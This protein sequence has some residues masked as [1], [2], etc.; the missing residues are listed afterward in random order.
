MITLP[1]EGTFKKVTSSIILFVEAIISFLSVNGPYFFPIASPPRHNNVKKLAVSAA[2]RTTHCSASLYH[3][4]LRG[5]KSSPIILCNWFLTRPLSKV[6]PL[7]YLHVDIWAH[8]QTGRS[9][10]VH[11]RE[12]PGYCGAEPQMRPKYS[13]FAPCLGLR[14]NWNY[15]RTGFDEVDGDE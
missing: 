10:F 12:A 15:K 1:S 11:W 13:L 9:R 8:S 4:G 5:A 14:K 3:K 7:T 2:W 6:A